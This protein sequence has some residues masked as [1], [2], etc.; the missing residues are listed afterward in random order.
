MSYSFVGCPLKNQALQ[1]LF[2]GLY[3]HH[4]LFHHLLSNITFWETHASMEPGELFGPAMILFHVKKDIVYFRKWL[5]DICIIKPMP[6]SNG[7]TH[8]NTLS[9]CKQCLCAI[10][11][12]FCH[13]L[14]NNSQIVSIYCN[15]TIEFY[16]WGLLLLEAT[17]TIVCLSFCFP[18]AI[19]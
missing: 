8:S 2:P 15:N 10:K 6:C 19:A 13:I 11:E 17:V 5:H 12:R 3:F 1:H 14:W 9:S 18:L 16:T 7:R 4:W